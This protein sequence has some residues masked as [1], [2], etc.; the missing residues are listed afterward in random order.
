MFAGADGFVLSSISEGLPNSVMEAMATGVPIVATDVGGVAELV[1]DGE[2]GFL[3]TAANPGALAKA[4]L[5]LMSLPS[6]DVA[7]LTA[8]AKAHVTVNCNLQTVT[9]SWVA[10]VHELVSNKRCN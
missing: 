9:E 6:V 2:T 4:M 7:N 3:V 1:R 5:H 10:L 8:A